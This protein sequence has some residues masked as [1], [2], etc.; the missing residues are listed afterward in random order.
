MDKRKKL[1]Y[2][3]KGEKDLRDTRLEI[4]ISIFYI[5]CTDVIKLGN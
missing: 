3:L 4:I 2:S 1:I 5:M